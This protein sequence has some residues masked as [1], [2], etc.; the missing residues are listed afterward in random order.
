[1]SGKRER[2]IFVLLLAGALAL[3][4][5]YYM[6]VKT[7]VVPMNDLTTPS[8]SFSKDIPELESQVIVDGLA[9]AWDLGFL[10]DGTM[11][12]TEREGTISKVSGGEKVILHNVANVYSRGEGGLM[13]L[14]VDPEFGQNRFIYACYN[15]AS[16][17]RI[18]RWIL[19]E[20]VTELTEQIDIVTGLPVN[21]TTFP[22]R[23]SGCRLRFGG[24]SNMWVGTGDVAVG[25]NPQDPNSLGGKILR[26][27]RD[28]QAVPGNLGTPYD[29]RI[30]SYGH[31]N[32]Q[33]LALFDKPKGGAFGYSV[34]H[35]PGKDDEINLLLP[36]NF[37][38]NPVPGYNE[39]AP[40]TSREAYPDAH[41]AVWSSG[42]STIAPSGATVISGDKWKAFQGRLAV[43]VLKDQHLRLFEFD[44][45]GRKVVDERQ[46]FRG[47]FG[48]IRSV[49]MGPDDN[50]YL[51]T[52][53][54]RNFDKIIKINPR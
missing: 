32:V 38:W 18:S 23:H 35:G 20:D 14:A 34:E 45:V 4:L 28:G 29:P 39:R 7:S 43:A 52:D 11:L 9:N 30:F 36:G 53:N 15:T 51:T 2:I 54:G 48:R 21:T 49:V 26:V 47:E 27:D 22:G 46:L 13:S 50:L 1:M 33:G 25:T 10:P 40:M 19:D 3:G 37:G 5:W 31:R 41:E 6:R 16:D 17:I 8:T 44:V 12:F 42:E 24:N